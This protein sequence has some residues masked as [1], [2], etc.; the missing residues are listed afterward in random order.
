VTEIR[1]LIG[2]STSELREA[3]TVRPLDQGE[4]RQHEIAL[5]LDYPETIDASGGLPVIL[6]PIEPEGVAEL[7]GRVSGLMLSG[8]PDLHPSAYGAAVDPHLGPTEP[9]LDHFE[10]ALLRAADALAMPILAVCRGMQALNV[11]RGGTLHQHLPDVVGT[12]ID[13]RQSIAGM[14]PTHWISLERDSFLAGTLGRGRSKVNSFH[15]QGLDRLGE[16]LTEVAWAADGT[17]EGVEDPTRPFVVGVQWHAEALAH[18]PEHRALFAAFIAAC[19]CYERN[20]RP[21]ARAA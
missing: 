3:K 7:V 16:G 18:R 10:L 15:H 4:P 1:P 6:P 5:G 2:V 17:I 21:L 12:E 11:A 9:E 13:H 20:A 8:G 14:R 19:E